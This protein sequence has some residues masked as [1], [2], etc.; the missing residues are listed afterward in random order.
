MA[1]DVGTTGNGKKIVIIYSGRRVHTF[2]STGSKM[3]GCL[4]HFLL[5]SASADTFRPLSNI[6]VSLTNSASSFIV[7]F[8]EKID[9]N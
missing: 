6:N 2:S 8:F 4:D 9:K 5:S 7:L 1:A 3:R